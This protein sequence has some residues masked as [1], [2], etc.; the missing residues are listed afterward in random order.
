MEIDIKYRINLSGIYNAMIDICPKCG[1]RMVENQQLYK[2]CKGVA[3][4]PGMGDV[5]VFECDKCFK[6]FFFHCT[7]SF[8]HY[9]IMMCEKWKKNR[10]YN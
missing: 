4:H 1:N 5:L 3:S 6:T 7:E 2:N 9:F 10:F 8:Y